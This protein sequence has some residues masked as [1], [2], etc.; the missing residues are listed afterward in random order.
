MMF[1][2]LLEAREGVRHG[3]ELYRRRELPQ[4]KFE[5]FYHCAITSNRI[6]VRT[7]TDHIRLG[8][9]GSLGWRC[10]R[11]FVP[12]YDHTVPPGHFAVG[13]TLHRKG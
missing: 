10:P 2:L 11:H 8:G 6:G 9:A 7:D 4:R 12:G 3:K 5:A 1:E 13:T